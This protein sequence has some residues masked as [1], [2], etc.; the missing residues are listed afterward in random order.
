MRLI[1]LTEKNDECWAHL[2]AVRQ[3]IAEAGAH[4]KQKGCATILDRIVATFVA[5][6]MAS[7]GQVPMEQR[8]TTAVWYIWDDAAG[9][10]RGHL[11]ALRSE[12]D[13]E[14]AVYVYQIWA[15]RHLHGLRRDR[16]LMALQDTALAELDH[17]AS[18]SGIPRILMY[19][20]R[21]GRYWWRRF[22][23]K[24]ARCM[25]EHEVGQ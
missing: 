13:G 9:A 10:L 15:E 24:L 4:F 1:R 14:P 23:F 11:V 7:Y 22:R 2:P 25:Y 5:P 18:A 20:Q 17:Y 19:T 3:A 12:W 8:E 21:P 6:G 16:E